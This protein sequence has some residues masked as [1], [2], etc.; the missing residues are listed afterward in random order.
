[1]NLKTRIVLGLLGLVGVPAFALADTVTFG[2]S[3]V[4]LGQGG[5]GA[6]RTSLAGNEWSSYGISLTGVSLYTSP[7]D[8][9]DGVGI[10]GDTSPNPGVISF[11]SPASGLSLQ[12]LQGPNIAS[13][14]RAYSPAGVLLDERN[15]AASGGTALTNVSFAGTVGHIEFFP[16]DYTAITTVSFTS[17]PSPGG[18]GV[19]S[20]GLLGLRRRRR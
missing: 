1:M 7:F 8:F 17:V 4:N 15:L 18:L 20:L 2:T 19:A 14:V 16:A 10:V 9:V 13:T 5:A 3:E 11:L 12:V 6:Y